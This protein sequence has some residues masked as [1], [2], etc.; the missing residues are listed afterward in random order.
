MKKAPVEALAGIYF[1]YRN[2]FSPQR[3]SERSD[4][5]ALAVTLYFLVS[6]HPLSCSPA[7][8]LLI[9]TY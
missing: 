8:Q 6:S 3:R 4:Y 9:I 7:V 1:I 2:F 5:A